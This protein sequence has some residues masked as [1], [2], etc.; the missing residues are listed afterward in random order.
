MTNIQSHIIKFVSENILSLSS[1]EVQEVY[2]EFLNVEESSD[3]LVR[4]DST[5]IQLGFSKYVD[6]KEIHKVQFDLPFYIDNKKEHT[7]MIVGMDAKASHDTDEII[8]STPYYLQSIKGRETNKNYYWKIIKLLGE[9]YNIYLSDVFKMYFEKE[10]IVSNEISEYI[11]DP[12]HLSLLNKEIIEIVNPIAIVSW[13]DKSRNLVANLYD[14][15]LRNSISKDNLSIP[16]YINDN[17]KFIATPHPSRRTFS[18]HWEDFF[19]SNDV[20]NDTNSLDKKL[21]TLI[22]NSLKEN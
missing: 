21:A 4:I 20:K 17:I 15:K 7:I 14:L 1:D 18:E 19:S 8:L 12:L 9:H 11:S 2:A 22:V 3:K 6:F 5:K 13:G 10:V 16:Y